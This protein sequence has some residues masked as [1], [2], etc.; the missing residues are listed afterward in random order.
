[1]AIN[2]EWHLKNKMPKYPTVQQWTKWHKEH[3][4]KCSC[5]PMLKIN[6]CSICGETMLAR[7]YCPKHYHEMFRHD[8]YIK[9]RRRELKDAL[10]R[11]MKKRDELLEK[12]SFEGRCQKCDSK[13]D[14]S[15]NRS[16]FIVGSK[17]I[18]FK[19]WN[20]SRKIKRFSRLYDKC[21]KCGSKTG[22]HAGLGLCVSCYSEARHRG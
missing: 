8:R 11:N 17:A 4:E 9:Y 20:D 14:I 22:K 3:Q 21:L 15:K 13:V 18:C 2:K 16:V 12:M 6:K 7:G 19:C 1:M 5:R 10:S